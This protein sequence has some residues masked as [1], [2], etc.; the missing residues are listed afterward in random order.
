[1]ENYSVTQAFASFHRHVM[2]FLFFFSWCFSEG[3]LTKPVTEWLVGRG[4]FFFFSLNMECPAVFKGGSG[5]R[6]SLAYCAKWKVETWYCQ[7]ETVLLHKK[8]GVHSSHRKTYSVP[9]ALHDG[10]QPTCGEGRGGYSSVLFRWLHNWTC[11]ISTSKLFFFLICPHTWDT[12][13]PLWTWYSSCTT[14]FRVGT[15][16][17]LVSRRYLCN[18]WQW[19]GGVICFQAAIGRRSD[20]FLTCQKFWTADWGSHTVEAPSKVSPTTV[21]FFFL[22]SVTNLIEKAAE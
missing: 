10:C 22:S 8:E 4:R 2:D 19:G 7:T 17:H 21:F 3:I 12:S 14:R 13:S 15:N 20:E 9:F 16:F 1:M 6:H 18:V 11:V 5:A